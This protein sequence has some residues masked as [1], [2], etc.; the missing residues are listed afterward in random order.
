[1]VWN[2]CTDK[3][4]ARKT[5]SCH[6]V[7]KLIAG[8]DLHTTSWKLFEVACLLFG[9]PSLPK[10]IRTITTWKSFIIGS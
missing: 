6:F 7:P 8:L 10:V 4:K 3:L 5:D 1:M 2:R 9:I